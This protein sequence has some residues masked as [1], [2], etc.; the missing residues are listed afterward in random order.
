[1]AIIKKKMRCLGVLV[2]L[3]FYL[4]ACST[5]EGGREKLSGSDIYKIRCVSCHGADGRMGM[6]GA[7]PLPASTLNVEQ[8]ISVVTTG[9]NIMPAFAGLMSKSEI[10][11]VVEFTMTLE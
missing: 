10:K 6:N 11:A 5:E 2:V 7:I 3:G 4:C 1:L 8:R 9:R